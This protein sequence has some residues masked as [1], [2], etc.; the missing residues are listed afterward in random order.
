MW[1]ELTGIA[2]WWDTPWCVGGDFNV[3]QFPNERL[4]ADQFTPAMNEFSEF[5]FSF[6]LMDIPL[7]GGKFTWFDNRESP[8]MS[9]IDRFLYSGDWESYRVSLSLGGSVSHCCSKETSQT[10]IRSLS[11]PV[12]EW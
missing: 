11:H 1:D 9:R 5:I 2:S 10:L 6:G 8:A 12:G 3:I 4:G 7:E